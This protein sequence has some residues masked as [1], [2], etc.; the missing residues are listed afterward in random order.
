MSEQ[1]SYR[2]NQGI[3]YIDLQGRID[4]N[5]APEVETSI[6][7]IQ[8][9]NPHEHMVLDA[10]KLT[11]ISSAGLRVIMR[12]RKEDADL[13]VINAVPEVYQ[14][15]EM[16]GFTDIMHIYKAYRHLSIDGC[17]F[18][19]KGANGAVYR[20][21]PETVV[22]VYFNPDALPEIEREL[23][24]SRLAFVL[25]VNTA[26]PYDIVRVG[27]RYGSVMELLNADSLTK[28]IVRDPQHLDEPVA[29][30]VDTLKHIH[31]IQVEPGEL[32][33]MKQNLLNWVEFVKNEL[34]KDQ[35]EKL[36]A[37]AEKLPDPNTLLHGDYHT[38]NIMLQNGEALLIDMDTLST[39]H[40]ILE[41]ACMYNAFI[42]FNEWTPQN[43]MD[44]YG[45]DFDTA[46]RF[47]RL[48][49]ARYLGT[50]DES[51]LNAVEQK[52]Q[53][54]GYTRLLRRTLRRNEPTRETILRLCKEKLAE[55]LP[56]VDSLDF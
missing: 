9:E 34:P 22:K 14:I 4:A 17:T 35:Y 37:L 24:N 46:K 45:F 13:S 50:T 29:Y 1:I 53:V 38:N 27:D 21:D 7:A 3:L 10:E 16:T 39:G 20:Y 8:K 30:Y 41:L 6:R 23:K 36:H 25:G 54:I 49:L 48:S 31:S 47:W 11:Y 19:A 18:I 43:C 15:F 40:P 5:N 51:V 33:R 26:I 44:F 12:L 2:V 55:V 28:M 52:A 56:Q 32:P 42:A